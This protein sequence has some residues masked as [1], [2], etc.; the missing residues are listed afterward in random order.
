MQMYAISL[1]VTVHFAFSLQKG[2][3]LSY[4]FSCFS[5]YRGGRG[6]CRLEDG[7]DV[8][9]LRARFDALL[10]PPCLEASTGLPQL[11]Q[12]LSSTCGEPACP[13]APAYPTSGFQR[14][15]EARERPPRAELSIPQSHAWSA[16]PGDVWQS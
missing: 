10:A 6:W 9:L 15:A 16:G 13:A 2:I 4:L 12:I 8:W 1:I 11:W 3:L 14:E 5:S 7:T